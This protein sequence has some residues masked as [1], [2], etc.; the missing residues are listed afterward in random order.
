MPVTRTRLVVPYG[1]TTLLEGVSRAAMVKPPEDITEF[2]TLY[3]QGLAA[4]RR[5]HP[6]LELADVV[7]EFEYRFLA[8]AA[9]GAA[10]EPA[11]LPLAAA[12]RDSGRRDSGSG[13]QEDQLP[14]GP[15]AR[16]GS[17]LTQHPSSTAALAGSA[18]P[19]ASEGAAG[20]EGAALAYV[21]AEPAALAAHLL[22]NSSCPC[23]PGPLPAA[24]RPSEDPLLPAQVAS[25]VSDP[26]L[27]DAATSLQTLPT[28]SEPSEDELTPVE[29][30]SEV[31]SVISDP[32]LR[33]VATS[34][35]TL[36]AGS[37]PSEDELTPAEVASVVSNPSLRDVATSVQTLPTGSQPSEDELL[38]AE[39]ASVVSNPSLRDVATSVQTLPTG[40]QPS[41]DELLPAEVASVVSNPSLRDV[42]TSVQTLP[43]GSQP[44]EDELTPAEVASVV[45]NPSLRDVATSVQTLP[46]ASQPTEDELLP[47]EVASVVSN[48]SLRDVA[49]SVQT[50]PAASEPSEDELT[51][52][53]GGSEVASVVSAEEA[54]A[55][56]ARSEAEGALPAAAGAHEGASAVPAAEALVEAVGSLSAAG[57]LRLPGSPAEGSAHDPSAAPWWE[58][59]SAS[60]APTRPPPAAKDPLW[61]LPSCS[62]AEAV[63][64]QWPEEPDADVE[65]PPYLEQFPQQILVPFVEQTASLLQAEQ[66]VGTG[67]GSSVTTLVP[68]EDLVTHPEG[69][70]PTAQVEPAE[71]AC[72]FSAAASRGE[73]PQ[74]HP[75]VWTLYC[76]TD[77]RQGQTSTPSLPPAG[78]APP[79]AQATLSPPSGQAQ[80]PEL[81]EGAAPTYVMGEQSKM[82][83]APPFILVGS[84]LQSRKH[85]KPIPGSAV[86]TQQHPGARRRFTM[87]PVPV[88]RPAEEELGRARPRCSSA[89]ET[90][91]ERRTPRVCAV[92]V[93]LPELMATRRGSQDGVKRRGCA[94][95]KSSAVDFSLQ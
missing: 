92:A 83:N 30:G 84:T 59:Q 32:S 20:P 86:F 67:Q 64:Q 26:S 3:F 25:V 39:V 48:P 49:T 95:R 76:L 19:P 85:W 82:G 78:A 57:E 91:A 5:E 31:A 8:D 29:G 15:R 68:S 14:G 23:C 37:Q 69:V 27:R 74:A 21:P 13:A 89:G 10:E 12:P 45:S 28:A 6:G 81:A 62:Q 66:P 51:P 22:G 61:A 72:A 73:Q 11:G 35:Q 53:E 4:F 40:S 1:L 34:V 77:L 42:A 63:A 24:C 88:A 80:Q 65:L 41:E 58:G 36:P 79:C 50:L 87:I 18:S 43:T 47:A 93:P 90:A 54:A 75:N 33:D 44:S 71:Q 94:R 16:C 38:P 2:F 7:E 52:A 17:T 9:S 70:E 60:P 56:G 55:E 46:A